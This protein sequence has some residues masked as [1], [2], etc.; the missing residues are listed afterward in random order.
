MAEAK[1]LG[2]G[3]FWSRGTD[4]RIFQHWMKENGVSDSGKMTS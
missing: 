2:W 4:V 1:R 3:Y